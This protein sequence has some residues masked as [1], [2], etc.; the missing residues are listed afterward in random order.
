MDEAGALA[1]LRS[2]TGGPDARPVLSDEELGNLLEDY[3]T[4]DTDGLGPQDDDYTPTWALNAAAAAGWRLK[5]GRVAGDFTFSADGSSF[6]K[7]EVLAKCAEMADRYAA[8]DVGSILVAQT[9]TR[10]D[11]STRLVL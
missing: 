7:G 4:A 5:A 3:R 1:R 6:S 8:L 9:E 11:R 2:M 10:L